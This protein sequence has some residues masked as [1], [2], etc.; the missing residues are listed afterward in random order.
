MWQSNSE[1]SS[2]KFALGFIWKTNN[3]HTRYKTVRP[4]LISLIDGDMQPLYRATGTQISH[5]NNFFKNTP[6]IFTV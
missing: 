4:E 6:K 5:Q 1:T 3:K 2:A